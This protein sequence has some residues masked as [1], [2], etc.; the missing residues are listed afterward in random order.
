VFVDNDVNVLLAAEGRHGRLKNGQN[1]IC[2]MIGSGIGG[3]ITIGSDIYRGT[4]G[5]SAEFGHISIDRNGPRCRCGKQGCLTTLA[6]DQFMVSEFER[7]MVKGEDSIV[8]D[9]MDRLGLSHPT[10]SL[11]VEAAAAGDPL[12]LDI[13]RRIVRNLAL[14]IDNLVRIFDPEV[15]LVVSEELTTETMLLNELQKSLQS[16][17]TIQSEE[18]WKLVGF[19]VDTQAWITGA[20]ELVFR[21]ALSLPLGTRFRTEPG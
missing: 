17:A 16:I 3:G 14:A 1:T 7:R 15:I 8:G 12:A 20:A 4:S 21:D 6:S 13:Y 19:S 18:K 9:H 10:V 11:I 2:V 5:G